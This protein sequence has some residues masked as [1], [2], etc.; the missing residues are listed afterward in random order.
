M[1]STFISVYWPL[2]VQPDGGRAQIQGAGWVPIVVTWMCIIITWF[3]ADVAK[4]LMSFIFR[5]YVGNCVREREGEQI[6]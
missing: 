2:S 5:K 1:G 6:L 4:T 3:A